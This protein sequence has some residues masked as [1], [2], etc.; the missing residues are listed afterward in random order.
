MFTDSKALAKDVNG[1]ALCNRTLNTAL[2]GGTWLLHH[3]LESWRSGVKR[4]S[5]SPK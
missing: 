5:L 4:I 3:L 2:E 1:G